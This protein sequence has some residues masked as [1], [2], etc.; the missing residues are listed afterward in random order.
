MDELVAR[1][2]DGDIEIALS[3]LT[4]PSQPTGAEAT[5][6]R[7]RAS[8]RGR[9]VW[10][11]EDKATGLEWTWIEFLEFLAESWL[12]L[13]IEDGAPLG[14]ALDTAPRMLAAAAMA[15]GITNRRWDALDITDL[16]LG[17]GSLCVR[18]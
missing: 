15:E 8:L 13:V 2:S 1:T 9:A 6:G 3:W 11:G 4:G 12:Y 14:V 16:I 7:L 18:V 10:Y 5:R 17:K